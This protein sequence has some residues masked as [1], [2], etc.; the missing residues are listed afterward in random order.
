ML[1][2]LAVGWLF[3]F[4]SM[5]RNGY[6]IYVIE[7]WFFSLL[8]IWQRRVRNPPISLCAGYF[9]G[10]NCTPVVSWSGLPVCAL[11]RCH[12]RPRLR[13]L[14]VRPVQHAAIPIIGVVS[15]PQVNKIPF[16]NYLFIL[17]KQGKNNSYNS[18]NLWVLLID[19]SR[20]L[21]MKTKILPLKKNLI[22]NISEEHI[23]L[24][25]TARPL[26]RTR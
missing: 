12:R 14:I 15:H 8:R 5:L 26:V 22:S 17:Y 23:V 24:Q 2:L 3:S 13:C 9:A 18:I 7:K 21:S 10:R 11:N 6:E 1:L 20:P 4:S 19:H 16:D 25:S